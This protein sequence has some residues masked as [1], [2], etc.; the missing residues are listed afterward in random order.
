MERNYI[1]RITIILMSLFLVQ[2][3]QTT[4]SSIEGGAIQLITSPITIG[5]QSIRG[6]ERIETKRTSMSNQQEEGYYEIITHSKFDADTNKNFVYI[7]FEVTD[8]EMDVG[9]L[10]SDQSRK[11]RSKMG[12]AAKASIGLETKIKMF[13]NENRIE[14]YMDGN[15]PISG[16][17]PFPMKFIMNKEGV[18]TSQ[19]GVVKS[20]AI[21]NKQKQTMKA[22]GKILRSSFVFGRTINQNDTVFEFSLSDFLGSSASVNHQS[23]A[24]GK[25]KAIAIGHTLFNGR[26]VIVCKG[27]GSLAIKGQAIKLNTLYY[28]DVLTGFAIFSETRSVAGTEKIKIEITESS[29]IRI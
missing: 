13:L 4:R 17:N 23:S 20:A 16:K 14:M 26:R 8:V 21:N 25:L 9:G 24:S 29:E 15:F 5:T 22:F 11:I 19:N 12:D 6:A 10:N 28:V 2:A 27:D 1:V 18:E 7:E 3:C